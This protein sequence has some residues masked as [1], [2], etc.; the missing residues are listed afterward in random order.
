MSSSCLDQTG[1]KHHFNIRMNNFCYFGAEAE[2][3]TYLDCVIDLMVFICIFILYRRAKK[4]LENFKMEEY[5]SGEWENPTYCI[6]SYIQVQI[7]MALL[8]TFGAEICWEMFMN[9]LG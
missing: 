8:I 6:I 4:N 1:N 5:G 3:M 7:I 2:K 9:L